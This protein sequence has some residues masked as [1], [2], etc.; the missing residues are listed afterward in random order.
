[1]VEGCK[2]SV[3]IDSS[4]F[5][6]CLDQHP[7]DAGMFTLIDYGIETGV[8]GN[9]KKWGFD[10]SCPVD[11]WL[12]LALVCDKGL[13]S[14]WVDGR[15]VG[16]IPKQFVLSVTAVGASSRSPDVDFFCG[17]IRQVRV[18][19]RALDHSHIL[20]GLQHGLRDA[21]MDSA[22]A[23]EVLVF[24]EFSG[25]GDAVVSDRG[26]LTSIAKMCGGRARGA[27]G[28][29]CLEE[30]WLCLNSKILNGLTASIATTTL[31]PHLD[32][33]SAGHHWLNS[34]LFSPGLQDAS[35]RAHRC[36]DLLLEFLAQDEQELPSDVQ[37]LQSLLQPH[38]AVRQSSNLDALELTVMASVLHHCGEL[39]SILNA[40]NQPTS[41]RESHICSA[42]STAARSIRRHVS[43][44][45]DLANLLLND[46]E[47]PHKWAEFCKPVLQRCRLLLRISPVHEHCTQECAQPI[48]QVHG[49]DGSDDPSVRSRRSISE[50]SEVDVGVRLGGGQVTRAEESRIQRDEEHMGM[51]NDIALQVVEFLKD[52]VDLDALEVGLE[53]RWRKA[54]NM[55]V[56]LDALVDLLKPRALWRM[57]EL[58]KDVLTLLGSVADPRHHYLSRIRSCGQRCETCVRRS[59]YKLVDSLVDILLCA[60][61]RRD[62]PLQTPDNCGAIVATANAL[63]MAFDHRD[64]S[65]IMS[66]RLVQV[67]S[68]LWTDT[69]VSETDTAPAPDG[70]EDA[71]QLAGNGVLRDTQVLQ[72]LN[73]LLLSLLLS[74]S[75]HERHDSHARG[76]LDCSFHAVTALFAE[77]TCHS[78]GTGWAW[79]Y[80][81]GQWKQAGGK[82]RAHKLFLMLHTSEDDMRS[83]RI[84]YGSLRYAGATY[85]IY[86]QTR[87][88]PD[89]LQSLILRCSRVTSRLSGGADLPAPADESPDSQFLSLVGTMT[90]DFR[91]MQGKIFKGLIALASVDKGVEPA[92]HDGSFEVYRVSSVPVPPSY[93]SRHARRV[94][95]LASGFIQFVGEDDECGVV[96]AAQPVTPTDN[97]IEVH[98]LES[99]RESA[100]A[101]GV[102]G[103]NYALDQMPGWQEGSI[104]YHLDDG[105]LF[106]QVVCWPSV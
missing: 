4:Q 24:V 9:H 62:V 64:L 66:T 51:V 7:G 70:R 77:A 88:R 72:S 106:V 90:N 1:M 100:V 32:D 55:Q 20:G 86:G 60:A 19:S 104:A 39:A 54:A 68:S 3:L 47:D 98:V 34:T 27:E 65:Y 91:L 10:T 57:H 8:A 41:Q 61:Q 12:L 56:G 74:L 17:S 67:L 40:G 69:P 49:A 73:R 94:I 82:A 30:H 43:Q 63:T 48:V 14:L 6:L 16:F 79:R 26:P 11:R 36:V 29:D 59:F 89:A 83:Q 37:V 92:G 58:K 31:R 23:N 93:F 13:T 21:H 38:L 97:Y 28:G 18:L 103:R 35:S 5:A 2:R 101:I 46:N 15:K 45:R 76:L 52:P 105:N 25:K 85:Q 33:D 81:H 22:V 96:Q 80:W 53:A 75:T 84:L 95:S 78:H 71:K 87:A 42:A 50:T 99:Q 102:A 44:H